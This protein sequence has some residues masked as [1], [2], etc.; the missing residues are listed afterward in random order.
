M[1]QSSYL[2]IVVLMMV[3][4]FCQ[5]SAK[6]ME[7]ASGN[8]QF[9]EQLNQAIGKKVSLVLKNEQVIS[10][11]V[12]EVRENSVLLV[13]KDKSFRQASIYFEDVKLVIVR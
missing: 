10:G 2:L 11:N 13:L 3:T 1:K 7:T 8:Y 5:V 4:A 9:A 12:K 6:D